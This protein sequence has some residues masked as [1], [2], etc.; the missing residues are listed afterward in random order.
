MTD[1]SDKG[2]TFDRGLAEKRLHV[3]DYVQGCRD[4]RAWIVATLRR[5]YPR[6]RHAIEWAAWIE[7]LPVA[8]GAV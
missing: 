7:A 5:T 1:S 2:I 8:Q 4:E 3:P 6:N